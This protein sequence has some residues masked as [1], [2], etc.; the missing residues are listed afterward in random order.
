R[1][2]EREWRNGE[3]ALR[4]LLCCG[5][6]ARLQRHFAAGSEQPCVRGVDPFVFFAADREVELLV[7]ESMALLEHRPNELVTQTILLE[8]RIVVIGESP[9][10]PNTVMHETQPCR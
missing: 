1:D 5:D 8:R 2:L 7:T 9:T 6:D 3:R 4:M 10:G